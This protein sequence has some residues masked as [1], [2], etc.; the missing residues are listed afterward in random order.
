MYNKMYSA[1]ELGNVTVGESQLTK[2]GSKQSYINAGGKPIRVCLSKQGLLA[3]W[4][5]S[6]YNENDTRC[7]LD[8][9]IDKDL[10]KC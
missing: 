10:E 2:N 5:T 8:F 4:G 1:F 3:P 6:S 9:V 7:N